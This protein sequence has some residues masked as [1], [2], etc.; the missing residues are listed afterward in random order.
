[1]M[2]VINNSQLI[3]TFDLGPFLLSCRIILRNEKNHVSCYL[4][5]Q[6]IFSSPTER[7]GKRV[8]RQRFLVLVGYML[9]TFVPEMY[10]SGKPLLW[11]LFDVRIPY[12]EELTT[13][14]VVLV[15]NVSSCSKKLWFLPGTQRANKVHLINILTWRQLE[16]E[17]HGWVIVKL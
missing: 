10:S 4:T 16:H 15:N 3:L 12:R 8:D 5:W 1:M 17:R 13:R 11:E 14:H 2:Y 9:S 7:T 6:L